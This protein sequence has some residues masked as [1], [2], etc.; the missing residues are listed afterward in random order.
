MVAGWTLTVVALLALL[1]AEQ[2]KWLQLKVVSKLLA[3]TGFV[4]VAWSAGARDTPHGLIM[5]AGL[6]LGWIG[7]AFLLS[8]RSLWFLS[9]LVAF[10]LG[11]LAYVVAFVV[12]GWSPPIALGALLILLIPAALVARW[13]GPKLGRMKAPVWAYIAV[14]SAM[15]ATAV[16]T[17]SA[18]GS[19]GLLVGAV[20][21][22]ISDLCVAR[23][24][25]V[26]SGFVNKLV[27]LPT[28][29]GGQLLL[30]TFA[31]T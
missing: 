13:L 28:Y 11:H 6:V 26:E 20:L 22:Y 24:R 16:A 19:A 5:L 12:R 4:W 14:I 17:W 27:G 15:L 7:D 23:E 2:R 9:G 21:F 10:L 29:Y 1:L 30:A 18:V 25:F 31:V 3:S 8:K